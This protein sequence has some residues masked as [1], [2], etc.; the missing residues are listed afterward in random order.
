MW[1]KSKS[2]I[3]LLS[4]PEISIVIFFLS[5]ASMQIFFVPKHRP[6][7]S[8]TASRLLSK[9]S[10]DTEPTIY[11]IHY[12]GLGGVNTHIPFPGRTSQRSKEGENYRKIPDGIVYR[13]EGNN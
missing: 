5:K 11:K 12:S 4:G 2:S 3:P 6:C 9:D 10:L 7:V 1:E 8:L 13:K